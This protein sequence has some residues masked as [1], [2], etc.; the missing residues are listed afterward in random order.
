MNNNELLECIIK[1]YDKD[2]RNFVYATLF[3]KEYVDDV[4]QEVYIRLLTIK[5]DTLC[6]LVNKET[7][8]FYI[9]RVVYNLYNN[10]SGV[11]QKYRINNDYIEYPDVVDVEYDME[12]DELVE[13]CCELFDEH[14]FW[15]RLYRYY[16]LNN[17]TMLDIS[18]DLK[19]STYIIR[20]QFNS[21]KNKIKISL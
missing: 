17:K 6:E 13:R 20:K 8:M 21:V 1:K 14:N 18:N 11:F 9:K 4:I 10:H 15:V 16:I 7:V 2:I 3:H 12:Y 5:N 19:L